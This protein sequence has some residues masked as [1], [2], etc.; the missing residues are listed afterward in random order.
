MYV[1]ICMQVSKLVYSVSTSHMHTKDECTAHRPALGH[2]CP[3]AL[4]V[5]EQ[6]Q[7]RS[8]QGWAQRP[9]QLKS[10]VDAQEI[11]NSGLAWACNGVA[12][13]LR[14]GR[15]RCSREGHHP[16]IDLQSL[17]LPDRANRGA[18]LCSHAPSFV[19]ARRYR[20]P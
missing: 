20:A 7:R 17:C 12:A 6:W 9:A 11:V 10:A 1:C 16:C 4:R 5:I 13:N 2:V 3:M 19:S 8:G 15:G 18:I 14:P